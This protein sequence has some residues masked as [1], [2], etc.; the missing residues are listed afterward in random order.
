[1]MKQAIDLLRR[2]SEK[3]EHEGLGGRLMREIDDYLDEF[4]DAK[5]TL[6]KF[7]EVRV[8]MPDDRDSDVVLEFPGGSEVT[9]QA[10]PSNADVDYNGSLDIILDRNR[11]VTNWEGDDMEPSMAV[12]EESTRLAK[13][14]VTELPG[15]YPA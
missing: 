1:M 2:I 14:L 11:N 7:R 3:D 9:I 10:R 5:S 6:Y 12:G 4:D 13:Q 15:E 8:E